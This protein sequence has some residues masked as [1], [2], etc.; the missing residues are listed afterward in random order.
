MRSR[1][2]TIHLATPPGLQVN[3]SPEGESCTPYLYWQ[4]MAKGTKAAQKLLAKNYSRHSYV[5]LNHGIE[6]QPTEHVPAEKTTER[7]PT[8]KT[9]GTLRAHRLLIELRTSYAPRRRQLA[10]RQ[11]LPRKVCGFLLVWAHRLAILFRC[12]GKTLLAGC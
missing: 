11:G 10:G 5:Q 12:T 3:H 9:T 7:L 8:N 1:V 4:N 6:G 2:L